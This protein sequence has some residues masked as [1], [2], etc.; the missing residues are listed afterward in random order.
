MNDDDV[1]VGRVWDAALDAE[2]E[3]R[4]TPTT[5]GRGAADFQLWAKSP[6]GGEFMIGSMSYRPLPDRK[7]AWDLVFYLYG[8]KLEASAKEGGDSSDPKKM[9][10]IPYFF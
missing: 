7:Q 1:Y 10:I 2:F 5:A 3:A 6:E 4:E 8:A 9:R